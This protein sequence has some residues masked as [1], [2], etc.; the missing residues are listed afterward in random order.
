MRIKFRRQH[1]ASWYNCLF[2]IYTISDL[3]VGNR[4]FSNSIQ[5]ID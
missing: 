1:Y 3:K 2:T 4:K 5:V